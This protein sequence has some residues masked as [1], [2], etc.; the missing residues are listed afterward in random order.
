MSDA[1]P[2]WTLRE[3]GRSDCDALSLIGA[4]TFLE[5]FAGA[6]SGPSIVVHCLVAHAS[7]TYARYFDE[8]A[9][10]WLAEAGEGGAPV[11]YALAGKPDL[12][13]AREGDIELKRIYVL[14]R[15]HGAGTGRA[16]LDQVV[17]AY[18]ARDRLVLGVYAENAKALSFYDRQGF[19]KI[20]TR[21]FDVGGTL[22]DDHVLARP[23]SAVSAPVPPV[24][25]TVSQ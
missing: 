2:A 24:Q 10:A 23:I 25:E 13:A 4:A 1:A 21:R 5:S 6:L 19:A 15:W 20:G 7:E 14:S 8:G 12:E 11:G 17:A 16:L 9:R 3:A 18:P 22:Y